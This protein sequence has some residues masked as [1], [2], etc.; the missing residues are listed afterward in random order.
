VRRIF[1]FLI[2]CVLLITT[3]SAAFAQGGERG[4]IWYIRGSFGM[5]G[6][7]LGE[8]ENAVRAEKQ[9]WVDEG[10]DISTY[11]NDFDQVWDYRVEVGAVIFR[12]F[13]LGAAFTFQPRSEDQRLGGILPGD[14]IRLAEEIKLR[15]YGVVGVLQYWI[16][17]K[18]GFFFGANGGY[19]SGRFEQITTA[20]S[21]VDPTGNLS[22]KGK[23]DGSGFVYG[24]SGG[25]QYEFLNGL[26][27]YLELGYEF[28][29]LGTFD[30]TTTSTNTDIVPESSGNYTV[31]GADVQFDFSGPFVSVGVGF[32]G[33]Y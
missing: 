21:T 7:D 19:G 32:L 31:D 9:G 27:L 24:F 2:A 28:R 29:D 22:A 14:Q 25:Y 12:N 1:P 16:P 30:G 20:A 17:G 23:Y 18:H 13:S 4:R 3:V 26:L 5:A 15:Y 8:L 6:H 10:I 11:A 33:P